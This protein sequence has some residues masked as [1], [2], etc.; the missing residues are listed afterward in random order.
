MHEQREMHAWW[1]GCVWRVPSR[2]YFAI[3]HTPYWATRTARCLVGVSGKAKKMTTM[4][5][6]SMRNIFS[7]NELRQGAGRKTRL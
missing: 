4:Y 7:V 6:K 2:V 5:H 1:T 3:A